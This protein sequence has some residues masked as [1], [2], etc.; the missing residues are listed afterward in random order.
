MNRNHDA[1]DLKPYPAMVAPKQG[2][3]KVADDYM[4]DQK[5]GSRDS[6]MGD[7]RR[8]AIV[9]FFA[10]SHAD[11]T[12]KTNPFSVL[13]SRDLYDHTKGHIVSHNND[14]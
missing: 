10:P 2:L 3:E 7:W 14:F 1:P 9:R 4:R 11:W 6:M 5:Y 13:D 12:V 8:S